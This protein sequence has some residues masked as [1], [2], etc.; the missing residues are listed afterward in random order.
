MCAKFQVGQKSV[1]WDQVRTTTDA[2]TDRRKLSLGLSLQY[3][4]WKIILK[5]HLIMRLYALKIIKNDKKNGVKGISKYNAELLFL[6]WFPAEIEGV[7]LKN[8]PNN[9]SFFCLCNLVSTRERVEKWKPYKRVHYAAITY[10]SESH[11]SPTGPILSRSFSPSSLLNQVLYFCY[12][13]SRVTLS[14]KTTSHSDHV[15]IRIRAYSMTTEARAKIMWTIT[16]CAE[17]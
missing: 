3:Q 5:C 12:Y 9:L 11:F 8:L 15:Y 13:V 2:W 4:I 16:L 1:T 17:K 6:T 10:A 7:P 14:A